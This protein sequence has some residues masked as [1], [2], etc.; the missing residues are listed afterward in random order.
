MNSNMG[1]YPNADRTLK[2]PPHQIE[3]SKPKPQ[4]WNFQADTTTPVEIVIIG[5]IGVCGEYED[6][7]QGQR[8]QIKKADP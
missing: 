1:Q 8:G 3:W 6:A 4:C 2:L 5:V 7:T